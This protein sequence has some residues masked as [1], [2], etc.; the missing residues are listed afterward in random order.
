MLITCPECGKE[1]YD[2]AVSCPNCGFPIATQDDTPVQQESTSNAINPNQELLEEI[3]SCYP[4][5]KI[6]AVKVFS[7]QSGESLI[8][9]KK[10]IDVYYKSVS[11]VI[12]PVCPTPSIQF[13][14]TKKLGP[15]QVDENNRLFKIQGKVTTVGKKGGFF[16]G[17]MAISTLGMSNLVMPGNMTKVGT[18]DCYDFSDLVSYELL[19]DDSIVTSGGVGQALVGG[20]VFG[21]AG[22]IAG[23]ITGKRTQKKK[24]NSLIIKVTL[25]NFNAPCIMIPLISKATKTDS[26]DYQNAFNQA[27]Q[28][29]AIL[30]VIT[31]NK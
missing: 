16:K 21:A 8:T 27:H 26:K 11:S 10:V 17:A 5:D 24:V 4:K 23:G 2:R 20:A 19:E 18:K 30:D 14:A 1:I 6:N 7:Q 9:S 13:R 28:I 25:N 29:L 22:A 31:H 3:Y 15:V 12:S